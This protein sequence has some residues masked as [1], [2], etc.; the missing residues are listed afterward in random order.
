MVTAEQ[1][2]AKLM[3]VKKLAEQY[4][5][6]MNLSTRFT[7]ELTEG[8]SVDPIL[9]IDDQWMTYDFLPKSMGEGNAFFYGYI[10]HYPQTW[11]E[12]A[13]QEEVEV[14]T[15]EDDV[16]LAA[17]SLIEMAFAEE[18][19]LA[20]DAVEIEKTEKEIK[21]YEDGEFGIL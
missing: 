4:L 18:L 2:I 20:M 10:K 12:P 11:H 9:T 3:E 17:R 21:H 15:F 1:Q 5:K 7:V 19:R 13:D 8:E 14:G 6:N 16:K